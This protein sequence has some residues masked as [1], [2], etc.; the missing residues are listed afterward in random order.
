MLLVSEAI[1][2]AVRSCRR[3]FAEEEPHTSAS[4][5]KI[6]EE[7]LSIIHRSGSAWNG[8]SS[9]TKWF[10]NLMEFLLITA[11]IECPD[12]QRPRS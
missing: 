10:S 8:G 5:N 4:T 2:G 9:C 3:N 11:L 1:F 12:K 6:M 7:P